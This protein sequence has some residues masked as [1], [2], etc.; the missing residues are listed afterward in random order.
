M[1]NSLEVLETSVSYSFYKMYL[2]ICYQCRWW[3]I[4]LHHWGF[5]LD[6]LES[7]F[8]PSFLYYDTISFKDSAHQAG[9]CQEA[10]L[11]VAVS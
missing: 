3:C 10:R 8:W 11:L 6:I 2:L 5:G 1:K 7:F 9:I 4:N